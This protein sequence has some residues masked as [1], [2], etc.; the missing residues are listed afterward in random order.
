[1]VIIIPFYTNYK[2]IV[3]GNIREYIRNITDK[4]LTL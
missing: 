3:I 4:K 1:M 2:K